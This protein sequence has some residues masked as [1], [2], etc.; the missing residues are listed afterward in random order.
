MTCFEFLAAD[1]LKSFVLNLNLL[2]KSSSII[3]SQFLFISLL[4]C[5][6]LVSGK[7]K[8][9]DGDNRPYDFGFDLEGN[10]HRKESKGKIL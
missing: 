3:I 2:H 8:W 7:S 1:T 6:R 10:Q 4:H 9:Y 5:T